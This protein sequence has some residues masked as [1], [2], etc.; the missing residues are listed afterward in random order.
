[1]ATQVRFSHGD[2]SWLLS[3]L[4]GREVEA[5]EKHLGKN[6]IELRWGVNASDTL[7]T[8]ATFLTRTRSEAEVEEIIAGM[9][10]ADIAGCWS[11]EDD[12]LPSEWEEGLPKSE[13]VEASTTIGSSSLPDLPG[14]GP[15]T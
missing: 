6:Y 14:I 15:L 4:T 2:E 1:M 5:L 7:A 3:D 8:L 13:V 10:I 12:D 9:K 11:I